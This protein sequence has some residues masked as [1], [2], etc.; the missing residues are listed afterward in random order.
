MASLPAPSLHTDWED[1]HSSDPFHIQNLYRTIQEE[2]PQ[3]Y[4][5]SRVTCFQAEYCLNF[6]TRRLV[7][8]NSFKIHQ[9]ACQT[10]YLLH[11]IFK[12]MLLSCFKLFRS[13]W[14][15]D[16]IHTC[17]NYANNIAILKISCHSDVSKFVFKR[18][19]VQTQ[20]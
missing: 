15:L 7:L 5:T 3:K 17:G 4:M 6:S 1:V 19:R 2:K 9:G 13:V 20:P 11:I 18:K 14:A 16:T 12:S 8:S 10:I